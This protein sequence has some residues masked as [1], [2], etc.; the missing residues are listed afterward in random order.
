MSSFLR[1]ISIIPHYLLRLFP[2]RLLPLTTA[3]SSLTRSLLPLVH[4][5]LTPQSR[6]LLLMPLLML[7]LALLSLPPLP[8]PIVLHHRLPGARF[9]TTASASSGLLRPAT[10]V[11]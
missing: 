9:E 6:R 7:V 10:R 3:F 5:P 2:P 1:I 8:Y 4:R 11:A